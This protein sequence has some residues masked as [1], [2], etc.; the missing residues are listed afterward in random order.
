MFIRK[1]L[2]TLDLATDKQFRT[3]KFIAPIA[4]ESAFYLERVVGKPV[5]VHDGQIISDQS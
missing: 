4:D 2:V 5:G 3:H 1:L